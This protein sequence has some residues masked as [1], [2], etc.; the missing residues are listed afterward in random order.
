MNSLL[1]H[2]YMFLRL[3]RFGVGNVFHINTLY[4]Q[5]GKPVHRPISGFDDGN[6]LW[7]TI[8]KEP[9]NQF[10]IYLTNYNQQ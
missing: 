6:K 2:F 9:I 3:N 1:S 7:L 5:D 8:F 10:K 4:F